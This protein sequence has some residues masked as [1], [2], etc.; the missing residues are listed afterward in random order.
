MKDLSAF[1][2]QASEV[3]GEEF[4][5]DISVLIPTAAPRVD[6]YHTQATVVVLAEIPELKSP[7]QIR[8]YLE[9]QTLVLEGEIPCLY[10][11]T[12]NRIILKER[13]FGSFRRSLTMPKPV[14]K[15]QINAKYRQ[16]L[17][18]IELQIEDSEQQT[19]VQIDFT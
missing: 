13:F 16:G 9:G 7:E 10:P 11:V 8:I 15:D 4:W 14:S 3:L 6:I 18:V 1:Q 19:Q 17:L 12:E 2:K 5:Q